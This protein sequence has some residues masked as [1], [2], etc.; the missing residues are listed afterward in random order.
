MKE[1]IIKIKGHEFVPFFSTKEIKSRVHNLAEQLDKDYPDGLILCPVLSGAFMFAADLVR[2]IK[3]PVE[4]NFIKYSSYQGTESTGQLTAELPFDIGRIKNKDVVIVEDIVDTGFTVNR[5]REIA[6]EL[7]AK[8]VRVCTLLFRPRAFKYEYPTPKNGCWPEYIGFG[9]PD[10]I[11]FVVGYGMDLDERYR[12]L[13][14][15]WSEDCKA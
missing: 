8:S 14:E 3:V 11:G 5:L 4:F 15:I 12:E 1:Q 13:P 9:L 6:Q 2:D 10:S 7:G